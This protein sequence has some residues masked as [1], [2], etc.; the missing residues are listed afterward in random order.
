[1]LN[2]KKYNSDS[3]KD[4]NIIN[5]EEIINNL[6]SKKALGS[7]FFGWHQ[8]LV[9][10]NF[11][12]IDKIKIDLKPFQEKAST[13]VVI[14][15]GGSYLGTYAFEQALNNQKNKFQLLYVGNN[16]S[17]D[18]L[19]E[20]YEYCQENDFVLNVISKSG[21][22]LET[23]LA[24][25]MFND[26]LI[27]KYGHKALKDRLIITTGDSG[28]LYEY[29]LKHNL[30]KYDIP[31]DIGGR[32]SVFTPVGLIPLAF[33]NLDITQIIK[34]AQQA[35][36]IY[37][38]VNENNLAYLYATERYNQYNNDKVVEA[39]INYEPS[40]QGL[41]EW[42][43]QLFGESEGKDNKGL[44]PISLTFSTDLHSL[45]Q[46]IQGGPKVLFETTIH[47]KSAL[48]NKEIVHL[49]DD[50]DKLN[51]LSGLTIKEI[52][53]KIE[54][55][56]LTAHSLEG[57]IPNYV[58]EIERIDEANLAHLMTFMMYACMYSA[59]LLEVNPFDQPDV[60]I[61]KKE[62]KKALQ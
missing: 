24:F 28:N 32:Y 60:E 16:I 23:A 15:I 44:L 6:D 49:D 55:S 29:A 56:V 19:I 42:L 2:F 33:I 4:I 26:L 50:F 17:S 45:G 14:G 58:I 9:D 52:A 30:L 25:R 12:L 35:A 59:Y 41:M 31:N 11:S 10:F 13:M 18:Y 53:D 36:T 3:K 22:T 8:Y 48:K 51:Q 1:M 21:S 5:L 7:D 34:A 20:V 47:I 37:Y 61:Y 39:F 43:K 38:Q 27:N 46:F 54:D 40:L 62:V 57:K